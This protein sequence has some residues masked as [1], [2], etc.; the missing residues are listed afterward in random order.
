MKRISLPKILRSLETLSPTLELDPEL[1]QRAKRSLD[2][3]LAI[4]RGPGKS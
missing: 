4:G 2:R 1:G 3:M